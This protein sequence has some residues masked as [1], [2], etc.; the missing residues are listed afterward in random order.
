MLLRTEVYV[1]TLLAVTS[2]ALAR[3][4]DWRDDRGDVTSTTVLVAILATLALAVGAIIV[5][6]VTQKANSIP[7]K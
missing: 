5:T 2:A 1:L 4:V 3:R 7:T 6:K